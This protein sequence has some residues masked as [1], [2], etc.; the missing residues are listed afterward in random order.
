[1]EL[2]RELNTPICF[3]KRSDVVCRKHTHP[4]SRSEGWLGLDSLVIGRIYHMG[5]F[6]NKFLN[7][8]RIV[9]EMC[10][11]SGIR[12]PGHNISETLFEEP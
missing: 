6:S 1:M 4:K 9:R 5:C 12:E 3:E 2:R 10:V 7:K 8:F 11:L